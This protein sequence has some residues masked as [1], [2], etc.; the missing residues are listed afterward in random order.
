MDE[1]TTLP[2]PDASESAADR[3]VLLE[4]DASESA[5]D[6]TIVIPADAPPR[7]RDT[8]PVPAPEPD[9]AG[10]TQDWK[11]LSILSDLGSFLFP[12]RSVVDDTLEIIRDA[13]FAEDKAALPASGCELEDVARRYDV[14][15]KPFASGGQGRISKAVDRAL[16]C[17][18]ALKSL[19]DKFRGD[20]HA[21][22]NFLREAKLTAALDHPSII[23]I[24]G[25]YGDDDNGMHLA[26]KMISGHTLSE[27]LKNIATV[28]RKKG[29]GRFNEAKSLR[30]RIEILLKVCEAVEYAHA[31][32]IIHRDLKPD[33]IMIG[34]HRET[35]VT[36]WG[37]A[38]HLDEARALSKVDGTPGYLAPEVLIERRADVRSDIYS[39]GI[40]L[41]ELTT[42]SPAFPDADLGALL[43]LVKAGRI[44]PIRHR[45]QCRIDAD[46]K[47]IIRKAVNFD[48]AR[49]YRSVAEFSED[50]RRYLTND[51]TIA[52][53][54]G[55][56]GKVCR[57][58]MNHR[59]GMLL[60]IMTLLLLGIAGVA[61]TLYKEMRWSV[62][63]RLR[64][65]AAGAVYANVSATANL[66]GKDLEGIENKLE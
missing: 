45:F 44:R 42:L 21:R 60:I 6:R 49:R 59:R 26:M 7:P 40:I 52:R 36:D 56:F 43:K 63:R 22:N 4:P 28:Y 38:T 34:R 30:N 3:T 8:D 24:H 1:K 55:L 17:E 27:Y 20:E 12:R 51:E 29:I 41:F 10:N 32:K 18:V 25:L 14:A 9:A 39:L 2:E 19:H 16:G 37:L 50:L 62:E 64:D 47:A 53:P 5:A 13:K 61:R 33:N 66:L 58:S 46:L 23:P 65:N 57:W 31:R 15:P 11:H 54:D 48:P 35:Y